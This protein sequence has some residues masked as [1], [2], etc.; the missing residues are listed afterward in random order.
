MTEDRSAVKTFLHYWNVLSLDVVSGSLC[1]A[2]FVSSLLR[3]DLRTAYWFLLPASV[4]VIYTTDHLIDGWRS[5]EKSANPRHGF[6]YKNRIFLSILTASSAASCFV[7][8]ILFLREWVVIVALI[9]GIFVAIHVIMAYLQ[10]AFFWKECSVSVLY[11]AGIWFGP[12]L[13]SRTGFGEIWTP[14]VCFLITA[15][16]NS[17]MNSYMEREIDRKENMQSILKSVSPKTLGRSVHTLAVIGTCVDGFWLC[18][19]S[20]SF[21]PEAAYFFLGYWIPSGIVF[22]ENRFRNSQMYR[23]LGEGYFLL[24]LI[25][26][27]IREPFPI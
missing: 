20:G 19:S 21:L 5:R 6:H 10:P 17:F 12:I 15:L 26:F 25:P 22:W 2:V 1:G 11:T 3:S 18:K 13:T 24:A 9:L 14:C 7:C 23:I 4:W 16:C 8:G 27:T